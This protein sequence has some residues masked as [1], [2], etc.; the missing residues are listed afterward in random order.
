LRG[1]T[2]ADD[3]YD[4]QLKIAQVESGYSKY[5]G[6]IKKDKPVI[7]NK[8][9]NSVT[10]QTDEK[11]KSILAKK[12]KEAEDFFNSFRD[13]GMSEMDIIDDIYAKNLKKLE[14]YYSEGLYTEERFHK[15]RENINKEY[16]DKITDYIRQKTEQWLSFSSSA[17]GDIMNLYNMAANNRI[18]KLDEQYT[19]VVEVINNSLMSDEQKQAKLAQLEAKYEAEKKKIQL[20]NAKSQKKIALM[21][22]MVDVPASIIATFRNMGG[23]PWGVAPAAIMAGIG[24]KKIQLIKE[25]PVALAKG[26]IA[27]AATLAVIGEGKY[28]EAVLP[29]SNETFR[30][31]SAGI[32][33]ER[34]RRANN[35]Q[36]VTN[37][38]SV[39]VTVQGSIIDKESFV[40]EVSEANREIE[41]R[42]GVQVYSRRSVY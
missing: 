18:A 4:S 8:G 22:A 19:K 7:K 17:L 11:T 34:A 30:Q 3:Y 38:N 2:F 27:E 12:Q 25:Q 16:Q 10:E 35:N 23:W 20:E 31:L 14:D 37:D 29:L 41:R 1:G 5:Q 15:L 21:Q 26:G 28:N 24:A 40:K 6:E 39:T 42:T 33:T 36:V 13:I 32:E 9:S